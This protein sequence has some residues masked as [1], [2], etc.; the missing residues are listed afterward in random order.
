[1]SKLLVTVILFLA[2]FSRDALAGRSHVVLISTFKCDGKCMYSYGGDADIFQGY[3]TLRN[4]GVDANDIIVMTPDEVANSPLNPWPGKIY[5]NERKEIDLRA[6]VPIDYTGEDVTRE[7]ILAVLQGQADNVQGGSGRVLK[8]TPKDNLLVYIASHGDYDSLT[9]P[10]FFRI[11]SHD[12]K[13]MIKNMH[14][15]K[16]YKQAIFYVI[17]CFS[18]SLFPHLNPKYRVLAITGT[19]STQG[20]NALPGVYVPEAV[21]LHKN[22]SFHTELGAAWLHNL[23]HTE[24]LSTVTVGQQIEDLS[25]SRFITTAVKTFGDDRIKNEP[26]SAFMGSKVYK[27]KLPIT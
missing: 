26:V 21:G 23:E 8:S 3:H 15:K 11:T 20:G 14:A 22:I 12:L 13:N 7:N 6:G 4:H 9:M 2:S 16:L 5:N 18:G 25:K 17:S 10:D 19:N 24:D 27:T 1:M